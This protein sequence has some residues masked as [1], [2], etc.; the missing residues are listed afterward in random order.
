[1]TG[2]DTLV[3]AYGNALRGDDGLAHAAAELVVA[4]QIP[5][6]RVLMVHQLTPELIEQMKHADRVLFMDAELGAGA[7]PFEVRD[8]EPKKSRNLF[9][10]HESPENLLAL[11]HHLEHRLPQ[12]RL[13]TVRALSIDHGEGLTSAATFSLNKA[14]A[15][16]HGFLMEK[17][18]TK[19]A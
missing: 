5:G 18:C 12:A 9:G 2:I 14:M 7:E 16:I 19:S 4:W 6:V 3:I 10:H 11:L 13:L 8:L 17:S 15:W 1:V